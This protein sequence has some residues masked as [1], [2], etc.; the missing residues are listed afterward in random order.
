MLNQGTTPIAADVGLIGV[1]EVRGSLFISYKS[2]E[3][4]YAHRLRTFLARAGFT[5]WWDQNLQSGGVWAEELD[6]Q[7]AQAACVIV[8]WSRRAALS[9][10]VRHE[11]SAAL[12]RGTYLPA[13]IEELMVPEPFDRIQGASLVGWDGSREHPGFRELLR[14]LEQRLEQAA[15]AYGL[16][17]HERLPPWPA[18]VPRSAARR[19]VTWLSRNIATLIAAI[20]LVSLA[21]LAWATGNAVRRLDGQVTS[22][23]ATLDKLNAADSQ[24]NSAVEAVDRYNRKADDYLDVT[25]LIEVDITRLIGV[26]RSLLVPKNIVDGLRTM[27]GTAAVIPAL[28]RLDPAIRQAALNDWMIGF[29]TDL[30]EKHGTLDSIGFARDEGLESFRNLANYMG[31]D[32]DESDTSRVL[33]PCAVV[34]RIPVK[35]ILGT[36]KYEELFGSK[37]SKSIQADRKL[38]DV[39]GYHF[40]LAST[41]ASD[42]GEP[43]LEDADAGD[44]NWDASFLVPKPE[45]TE[46]ILGRSTTRRQPLTK[47]QPVVRGKAR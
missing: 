5:V 45:S 44:G 41:G 8:L 24:L 10:W 19:A 28:Q 31:A 4:A 47:Q 13:K 1:A 25:L 6:T 40:E 33:L 34:Y 11:A 42:G 37:V 3:V 9:A 35:K 12:A 29:N 23:T 36:H 39:K 43:M 7:L 18:R 16:A 26:N 46:T 15:T 20:A 14:S 17:E 2:E 38:I 32:F 22:V 21:Y 27:E 30:P